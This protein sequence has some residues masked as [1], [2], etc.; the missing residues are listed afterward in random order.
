MLAE[1]RL[2]LIHPWQTFQFVYEEDKPL[3]WVFF[4]FDLVLQG[5]PAADIPQRPSSGPPA[6]LLPRN[7][8]RAFNP[9]FSQLLAAGIR[10]HFGS[11]SGPW[12]APFLATLLAELPYLPA[13]P[14]ILGLPAGLN[15]LEGPG[16]G[17]PKER[18][19]VARTQEFALERTGGGADC[20]DLASRCGYSESRFRQRFAAAA[21]MPLGSY[22][23]KVRLNEAARLLAS[24]GDSVSAIAEACG[25]S[26]LYAFSRCFKRYFGSAP[27]AFRR[28]AGFAGSTVPE[29]PTVP[30]RPAVPVAS[31]GL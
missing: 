29:Q 5:R 25:F 13:V 14:D 26:S 9:F 15:G 30:E 7:E 12:L 8:V 6:P 1:D 22:I 17:R 21:G 24:S 23:R 3:R 27:T 2:L 20:A 31:N 19:L 11:G 10:R 18:N 4:G 28:S 16:A